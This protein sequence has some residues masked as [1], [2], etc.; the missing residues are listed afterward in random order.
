MEKNN[1][2]SAANP[3]ILDQ[4]SAYLDLTGEAQYISNA[5]ISDLEVLPDDLA[6]MTLPYEQRR[7]ILTSDSNITDGGNLN[8]MLLENVL[9]YALSNANS[10]M[11]NNTQNSSNST[12]ACSAMM[13]ALNATNLINSIQTYLSDKVMSGYSETLMFRVDKKLASAPDRQI[14]DDTDPVITSWW[15]FN[16]D[17]L[18]TLEVLDTQILYGETYIY[19]CFIYVLCEAEYTNYSLGN[20]L[21]VNYYDPILGGNNPSNQFSVTVHAIPQPN[22]SEDND[23]ENDYLNPRWIQNLPNQ[24]PSAIT[25][26]TK[27]REHYSK[28]AIIE[29]PYFHEEVQIIDS[30]PIT[31]DVE[32]VGYRGVSDKILMMFNSQVNQKLARP[33]VILEEDEDKFMEQIRNQQ[34]YGDRLSLVPSYQQST[35][36]ESYLAAQMQLYNLQLTQYAYMS[37]A[38]S[39]LNLPNPMQIPTA[40]VPSFAQYV[41]TQINGGMPELSNTILFET[42]DPP[43]YIQTFRL[44]VHPT[45]YK[46]FANGRITN[47]PCF[48]DNPVPNPLKPYRYFY[49]TSYEDDLEPN[50]KYYYCFRAIDIHGYISNP[51][52][53]YE[54]EMFKENET[55]YLK[56]RIVDMAPKVRFD[57]TKSFKQYIKISPAVQQNQIPQQILTDSMFTSAN[58]FVPANS[59]GNVAMPLGTRTKVLWDYD[60]STAQEKKRFKFRITSKQTGKSFDIDTKF[61]N[62]GIIINNEEE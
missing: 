11:T 9:S 50:V 17:E 6:P 58:D 57:K 25:D 31:P 5:S 4:R 37:M 42:D 51:S 40:P 16:S 27:P 45:E 18:E 14:P 20:R 61:T 10:M 24:Q 28:W 2:L 38:Y 30:P 7:V 1:L 35:S 47:I 59:N 49:S 56:Q 39:M 15:F 33:I 13:Q 8:M 41:H 55:I 44:R 29:V 48:I 34:A 54:I 32:I 53:V 21:D 60:G 43:L 36:Y 46:D 12:S 26:S 62:N 3:S 22:T 19:E 23:L 52:V